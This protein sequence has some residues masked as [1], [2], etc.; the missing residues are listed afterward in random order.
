MDAIKNFFTT[1]LYQPL[2]NALIFLA[3]I[4]PSHSIGWA[5]LLLTVIIRLALLPSSWKTFVHQRRLQELQ[6]K[7]NAL[8]EKHGSDRAA[9]S[10]AIM[11]LYASEK[12]SPFSTCLP[13]LVQLPV[14][15]ALYQV[16]MGGLSTDNFNLLYSF[17]PHADS[18]NAHWFNLDLSKPEPLVLPIL[19]A[20]SQ[21]L[22]GRQMMALTMPAANKT[23]DPGQMMARQMMFI[24]PIIIYFFTLRLPAA[25]GLYWLATTVFM[26]IQQQWFMHR[27]LP[28]I[29]ATI[30]TKNNVTVTIRRKGEPIGGKATPDKDDK[31]DKTAKAAL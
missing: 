30:K 19:V 13:T 20:A 7:I 10:Q 5:I 25:L 22:Q 17:T 21:F 3:W 14:L 18:I 29:S 24:T 27:P 1:V 31:P 8:K 9:H 16:F 12:V 26:L 28:K 15:I 4:I 23:D 6:P 11:E 2:F